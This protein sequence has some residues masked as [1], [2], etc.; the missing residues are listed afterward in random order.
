[1]THLEFEAFGAGLLNLAI[2]TVVLLA[3]TGRLVVE[4]NFHHNPAQFNRGI[5][6]IQQAIAVDPANK[7]WTDQLEEAKDA[8]TRQANEA[9]MTQAGIPQPFASPPKLPKP[10]SSSKP[11]PS[12]HP[13]R[14][15]L[16]YLARS[17]LSPQSEP[18][19]K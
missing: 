18:T 9:S 8:S 3:K 10:T 5:E 6:L 16:E 12:T 4:I 1:M 14:S 19:A 15:L 13:P 7:E 2:S 17:G 11:I